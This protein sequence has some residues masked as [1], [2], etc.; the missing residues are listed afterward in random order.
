MSGDSSFDGQPVAVDP[1]LK[2]MRAPQFR[3]QADVRPHYYTAASH[4]PLVRGIRVTN[5][6]YTGDA[7]EMVVSVHAEAVG[8]PN[9]LVPVRMMYQVVGVN[10]WTDIEVGRLRPNLVVLASLDELVKGDVVVSIAID[11]EIVEEERFPVEFLAYNQWFYSEYDYECLTAF[12]LPNHPVIAEIMQGVRARLQRNTGNGATEGYQLYAVSPEAGFNR[13]H[14][15]VRAIYE[16]VQSKDLKYSNP[17]ASFEGYGQKIRTPDVVMRERAMTCLDSTVLVASCI[18]AAGLSPLIFHVHGHAFPGFWVGEHNWVDP[19]GKSGDHP[20]RDAVVSNLNNLQMLD[21][22]GLIGSFESTLLGSANKPTFT[23]ALGQHKAWA[24]GPKTQE[25]VAF[26][27]VERASELGVRRLPNRTVNIADGGVGIELDDMRIESIGSGNKDSGPAGPSPTDDQDAGMLSSMDIPPKVRKWMDALLDIS[28]SNDL[29]SLFSTP[30]FLQA[31]RNRQT[32]AIDV[33]MVAGMLAMVENAMMDGSGIRIVPTYELPGVVLQDPTDQRILEHFGA[34]KQIGAAPVAFAMA[35][36]QRAIEERISNG[37]P[38]KDAQFR[39]DRQI[40]AAHAAETNRRFKTLRKLADEVEADSATN[41]LFITI[42]SLLWDSPDDTGRKT[43]TVKSPLFMIPVRVTGSA[44]TAFSVVMEDGGEIS[45]NYCLLEKLRS[46]LGLRID[47]LET[48]RIDDAG[49]DVNNMISRIRA[50]LGTSRFATM[51]VVEDCQLAVLDFATFRMWKDIQMNW[52]LFEKNVVVGHLIAGRGDSLVQDLP[53]FVGE[54]LMPFDCDESQR[55]AV[56]WALEGRSFVLE[57]PPGTGKSQTIANL[58]AASMAEGKRV[59]F[60]AEKQVAL[61]AVAR[62]L[63]AIG[64]DPFCITMHHEGTTPESIRRQ[65]ATSLDFVGHDLGAQWATEMAVTANLR[66]RLVRYREALV[67]VNALGD[68]ATTA[69]QEVVRLGEGSMVD[70]DPTTL[71]LVGTHLDAVRSAL[72]NIRGVVGAS[73]M[74]TDPSWSLVGAS[75][76]EAIE[77]DSLAAQIAELS[78]LLAALSVFRPL[79]ERG[80]TAAQMDPDVAA[81]VDVFA[82]GRGLPLDTAQAIVDPSWMSS[83]ED[84]V[85]EAGAVLQSHAAVFDFFRPDAITV[86]ITPQMTAANEAVNSGMIGRKKKAETLRALVAPLAK[87]T[88]TQKPAEILTLLQRLAPVRDAIAALRRRFEAIAHLRTPAGFDPLDQAQLNTVEETARRLVADARAVLAPGAHEVRTLASAGVPFDSTV[89]SRIAQAG[90]VWASLVSALGADEKLIVS[91][92]GDR[93]VLDALS[94]SL[95]VWS[96]D[97]PHFPALSRLVNVNRA[98]QPLLVAGQ[99]SLVKEILTGNIALDSIHDEFQRGLARASRNER[100][101]TAELVGFDRT[102]FDATVAEYVRRDRTCKDLMTIEI[103][104]SLAESRPFRPS[105]RMGAIGNLERELSKKVRRVSIPKLIKEYGE[106]ITRLTPCFLMSPEAVSRLLPADSQFFDIVVFDE[107]SQIRVAAAIPAMGR[108]KSAVIVGDSLQ[109]PPSKRVGQRQVSQD[110]VLGG[111]D[112]DVYADLESILKECR[113]SHLPYLMLKCHFR[114]QHEGLI[115]FSNRMFYES[116]LV[117]FPAPN[118]NKIS[119]ITWVQVPDGQFLRTGEGKQTNP[120]EAQA[121]VSEIQRRLGSAEHGSKSIGVV[122]F[123]ESQAKLITELLE[124]IAANDPA[125]QRALTMPKKEDRLFV[126]PLERVQGDERDTI[127]LSVSYSYQDQTRTKVETKWGPLTNEGG[128]RRLNVAITRS[129]IDMLVFCSFNPDHVD[130][131]N[132][133]FDGVPRTV[134]FLKECRNASL[135]GGAALRTRDVTNFDHYRRRLFGQLQEAGIRVRENVGLS[136]F[137]I[138]LAVSD[139]EGDDQFL[140]ILLDGDEWASR[141]TPYDRDILPDS[142][143]RL[144]GWRRVGRVWLKSTVTDSDYVLRTVKKEMERERVRRSLIARLEETGYEVRD[145]SRLSRFGVD[146]AIRRP[147]QKA[148][149]LAVCLKGPD[150]FAQYMPYDGEKPSGR[151]LDET[152]CSEAITLWAPDVVADMAATLFILDEAF[153]KAAR[154]TA[155][156]DM[157]GWDAPVPSGAVEVG[158]PDQ[159]PAVDVPPVPPAAGPILHSSEYRSEFIDATTLPV[160]GTQEE[161]SANSGRVLIAAREIVELEGPIMEDRLGSILVGRFG[162]SRLRGAR[163]QVLLPLFT[164]FPVTVSDFGKVYWSS[165]RPVDSWTG[166]RTSTGETTRKIDEVPLEELSNAMVD[167]VRMGGTATAQEILRHVATAFGRKSLTAQLTAHLTAI[168]RWTV[169][170]GRLVVSDDLH[171]LPS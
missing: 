165:A 75:D 10:D 110:D 126:V 80:L 152:A 18:A 155:T 106:V 42:G 66:E 112:D 109:M 156:R 14:E 90:K 114:S 30:A 117:T 113:E 60:V 125:V 122:T 16:E 55:E 62:K 91:W 54:P 23:E 51:Q 7:E 127:M 72:L 146:F 166:Y 100:L 68:S 13:V 56:K 120:I 11:G 1:L 115:S 71:P 158:V 162:M 39:V 5:I 70:I 154:V 4:R 69:N 83:I 33:P 170:R 159:G 12:V 40:A 8:A 105:V 59:L 52:K 2:A 84:A 61:N 85:R 143:L 48:P 130:V 137:R 147:D 32:R 82:S 119:P 49:I 151:F 27:D 87:S 134:E 132:S 97:A 150:L 116:K 164:G 50:Q 3:I 124:G 38:P 28:N 73:R 163:L 37:E 131:S 45:P 144:I 141:A 67:S 98:L 63:E 136:K 128:E 76:P 74:Q 29:V 133:K 88:V 36:R 145:D 22:A 86:D 107:A 78:S 99:A 135:T 25:F 96:A 161:L 77:R 6:G 111:G 95:P 92:A 20:S 58:I 81:A 168:L 64:L 171:S 19:N 139:D 47:E 123:N 101:S 53:G 103:P 93:S 108:A 102:V 79:L 17:P 153:E 35:W 167:V 21:T 142:T 157:A 138:D 43:R 160:V 140:A 44:Q 118:S 89:L 129:K 104:R 169:E 9:L 41:Q 46:E 34:T 148:W 15:I 24:S 26:V 121:V 94:L 65:L 57:G 31:G 149:P